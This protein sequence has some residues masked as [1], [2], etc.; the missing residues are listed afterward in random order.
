MSRR[1]ERI[2]ELIREEL[3]DLLL[4]EMRDPRLEG[5]ISITRVDVTPDLLNA[6]VFVS[7]MSETADQRE[8]LKA[9]RSAAGFIHRELVHRLELRRVPFLD[10]RLD[11]SIS[12]GAA[13]LAHI[14]E[15]MHEEKALDVEPD[16][17]AAP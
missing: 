13:I 2:N 4:R 14:D 9:L 12:E 11:T 15:V 8:A 10:F 1:T 3:S 16:A 6:R 7:V 5:L 17:G